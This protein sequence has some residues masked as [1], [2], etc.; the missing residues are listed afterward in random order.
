MPY[1]LAL[2]ISA[3]DR[4]RLHRDL[5]A[6]AAELIR[7]LMKAPGSDAARPYLQAMKD[8][9]GASVDWIDQV[10]A[11]LTRDRALTS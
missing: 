9:D 7:A 6:G 3:I 11:G 1:T 5:I 10:L 4:W 2:P 8:L